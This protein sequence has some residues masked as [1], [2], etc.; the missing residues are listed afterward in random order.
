MRARLIRRA[1]LFGGLLLVAAP[2]LPVAASPPPHTFTIVMDKMKFGPA[3]TGLHVGDTIIWVNHDLFRH[4]A[5]A[6]NGAFDVDLARNATARTVLRTA[7]S[8]P[9]YCRFH[10]GMTGTLTVA[11]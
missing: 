2:A 11:R 4:T 1:A 10:P 3:P 5:T 8:L 6:R 7:G 9:F